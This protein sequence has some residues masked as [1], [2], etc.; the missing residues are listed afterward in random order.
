MIL[1]HLILK[2]TMFHRRL[3]PIGYAFKY[4]MFYLNID[5][6]KVDKSADKSFVFGFNRRKLLSIYESD[7][8]SSYSGNLSE[9]LEKLFEKYEINPRFSSIRLVT[10][11]RVFGYVFNPVSFFLCY[12][13]EEEPEI[14]IA[15]VHNTFGERHLYVM[16]REDRRTPKGFISFR[17]DKD[18][19]VSPFLDREGVYYFRV[20]EENKKLSILIDLHQDDKVVFESGLVSL[21]REL[22]GVSLLKHLAK[23]PGSIILTFFRIVYHAFILK[24]IK[25]LRVFTKPIADS[26]ATFVKSSPSVFQKYCLK[27]FSQFVQQAKF[28]ELNL[29]FPCGN[30][31]SVGDKSHD[32]KAEI[33]V[34]NYDMFCKSVIH[35][36]IGFGESYVDGDWDSPELT[37]V[38]Q[39]FSKNVSHIDDRNLLSTYFGRFYNAIKHYLKFNSIKN[40]KRN[41]AAHYDLSNE[42]FTKF[43]DKRMQY[44]SALFK[45]ADESLEIAQ[46]NKIEKIVE[47]LKIT[48][49]SNVL[50][51]GCGWGGLG[52]EIVKM[53]GCKYTGVTLSEEQ[54]DYFCKKVEDAGLGNLIDVRLED[55]RKIN[56]SFDRVIS[57][58]MVEAVGHSFLESYFS[59]I[60]EILSPTGLVFIQAITIPESRYNAY[61]LGCDWI[62][63]YV[64][65]GGLCP[66]QLRLVEAAASGSKLVLEK[67]ENIAESYAK[68]LNIWKADFNEEWSEIKVLGFDERFRRLWNY[69]LSYC[70]AGFTERLVNTHQMVFSRQGN[71]E[72]LNT[73]IR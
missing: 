46:L 9:K 69:Y 70:E 40:S 42:L 51:I 65:P 53:T 43:L 25:G 73:V 68:T 16:N 62:Q 7:Y 64:F 32:L 22:N 19:H 35:G 3:N 50:E 34:K 52:I 13:Q 44:S 17:A 2:T 27:K 29:H 60:G 45:N 8:L 38:I 48:N 24:F 36:D 28:G 33:N 1:S 5:V 39:F 41:I 58:E 30:S 72:T 57:I 4:S 20:K 66:S 55:Y 12:R 59:K 10:H 37:N 14:L 63:K 18:F 15:E 61:R 23:Y 6:S 21:K 49:N 11:P 31:I 56:G 54:R 26:E 47:E 67:T 71:S